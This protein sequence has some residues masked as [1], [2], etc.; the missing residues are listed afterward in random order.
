MGISDW[1]SFKS[2]KQREKEFRQYARWAYPYGDAQ[3]DI[4]AQR[5]KELLPEEPGSTAV[6]VYLTGRQGYR[7]AWNMDSEDLEEQQALTQQQKLMCAVDAMDNLL[8]GKGKRLIFKYLAM[9]LADEQVDE[10][11]QYPSVES[12]QQT[13]ENLGKL[14]ELPKKYYK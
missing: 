11:L 12:L 5:L 7:G 8:P 6:A 13:A 4:V 9:I 14:L 1:F 10:S 2:K 3:K